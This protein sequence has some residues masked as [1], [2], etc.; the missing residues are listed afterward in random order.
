MQTHRPILIGV[1]S[2][3]LASAG[4][5]AQE[6]PQQPSVTVGQ[7]VF[8]GEPFGVEAGQIT[9]AIGRRVPALRQCY[10]RALTGSPTLAGEMQLDVTF[11]RNGRATNVIATGL[12][13]V[14]AVA[15]CVAVAVRA[16]AFPR[17]RPR[18]ATSVRFLLPVDFRRGG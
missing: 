12:G 11:G 5:L 9:A 17:L 6:A 1:A 18:E 16:V 13:S 15:Q 14:P 7:V 4:A 10:T 3:V 2:A 8:L